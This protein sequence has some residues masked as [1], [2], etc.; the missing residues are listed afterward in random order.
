MSH[1]SFCCKRE[2]VVYISRAQGKRFQ[3]AGDNTIN[4]NYAHNVLLEFTFL[5]VGENGLLCARMSQCI[6]NTL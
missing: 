4:N 3:P 6:W 1:S 2:A 5:V